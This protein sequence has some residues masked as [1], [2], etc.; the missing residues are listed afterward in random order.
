MNTRLL[1]G[2]I[3]AGLLVAPIVSAQEKESATSQDMRD[4]IAFQRNKDAADARQARQ[5]ASHSNNAKYASNSADR[6]MDESSQGSVQTDKPVT[7][8]MSQA[9]AW[10]RY[11]DM[12]AARQAR[13]EGAHPSVT[14]PNAN[15]SSDESKPEPTVKDPGPAAHKDK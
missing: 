9:I 15:R 12:A 6:S 13:L 7:Q 10:E 2:L 4:A 1:A 3:G 11:K 5:E 14:S 8:S